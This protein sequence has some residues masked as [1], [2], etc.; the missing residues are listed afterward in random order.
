MQF[1][2]PLNLGPIRITQLSQ[3]TQISADFVEWCAYRTV[4]Q[5]QSSYIL[6]SSVRALT[7]HVAS[8]AVRYPTSA[9]VALIK[10]SE[11]NR[12]LSFNFRT[13]CP[14]TCISEPITCCL[15]LPLIS[16]SLSTQMF[17]DVIQLII[18]IYNNLNS[19]L[20]SN[21]CRFHLY[22]LHCL[23]IFEFSHRI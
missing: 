1:C 15:N 22:T 8:S 7:E 2:R 17:S 6:V 12:K 18:F 16:F 19:N 5:I 14:L 3:R 20:G 23:R 4:L 9:P 11:P 10:T 21:G 13:N